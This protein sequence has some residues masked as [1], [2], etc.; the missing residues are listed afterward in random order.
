MLPIG[1]GL[2]RFA[3]GVSFST[4]TRGIAVL[5]MPFFMYCIKG[6]LTTNARRSCPASTYLAHS[7]NERRLSGASRI[8]LNGVKDALSS[9]YQLRR[10]G[11]LTTEGDYDLA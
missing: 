7:L 1:A 8:R 6:L 4:E 5:P 3:C 11:P 2:A 10:L 9:H